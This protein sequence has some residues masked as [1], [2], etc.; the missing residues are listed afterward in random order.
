MTNDYRRNQSYQVAINQS[1]KDRVVVEIGTGKDAILARLCAEAGAK[2][3]YAIERDAETAR[4]AETCVA[5]LGLSDQITV[6]HGDA[7]EVVLPELADIC[8]SEIV[9]SIG[10]SEG[11][12]VIIN[13]SRRLLK[14]DGAM[15]PERSVTK[16]AAVTLPD[17][18]LHNPKFTN[19]SGHYTDKIFEQVGYSFDLRV[20]IKRFPKSNLLSDVQVFED[21]EFTKPVN[22]EEAHEVEFEIIQSGRLDGFLVWLNLHTVKGEEIDILE[23]E[24]CWLPI[25]FPVFDPAISV[26]K[27][28]KI[29]AICQRSLCDNKL[30]PDYA[31]EGRLLKTNGE[32]IEFQHQSYHS[33]KLFKQTP[34][35]QRLFA[36]FSG[37]VNVQGNIGEQKAKLAARIG[38]YL[39][40]HLPEYMV[41]SSLVMMP[42]LP[43]TPNGK[44]NRKSLPV[45]NSST[46][47]DVDY[48][49]P[50]SGTEKMIAE[51]WQDVL[52]IE[53]VGIN[54]NFFELGGNSLLLVRVY[55]Q[56]Q[57]YPD[58][59]LQKLS[60]VDLFKYP[61]IAAL[62]KHLSGKIKDASESAKAYGEARSAGHETRLQQRQLRQAHRSQKK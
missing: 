9:G 14:S 28:D 55:N 5:N 47:S 32:A 60:M 6:V 29:Q 43:L 49:K 18:I 59:L 21:L 39:R 48:V 7:T 3:V 40:K 41:P 46:R 51:V 11:A 20:C 42:S 50:N 54:D 38:A 44:I 10:G 13:D 34:F 53:K 30:N 12:A 61:T 2:K 23:H 17:E 8:V 27:G 62:A 35:Y 52:K 22:L 4:L 26:S 45:P 1:V 19:V 16:I 36:D 58:A 37:S 24:H 31:I 33:R 57:T 25:Y 15:I 56:L